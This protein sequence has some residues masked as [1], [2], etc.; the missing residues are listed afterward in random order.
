MHNFISIQK[1]LFLSTL[2]TL[3]FNGALCGDIKIIF[4]VQIVQLDLN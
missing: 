2:A 4:L 1:G 3:V